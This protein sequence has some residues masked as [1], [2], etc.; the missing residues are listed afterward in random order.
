MKPEQK[1]VARHMLG[2]PN[3]HNRSYRNSYIAAPGHEQYPVLEEMFAKRLARRYGDSL[4]M[5]TTTG[6][7]AALEPGERLDREDFAARGAA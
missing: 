2:L 3:K 1:K 5:L 7:Q 6:A 4:W